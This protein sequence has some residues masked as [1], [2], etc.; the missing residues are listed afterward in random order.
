MSRSCTGVECLLYYQP[1]I[2]TPH[3]STTRP[4]VTDGVAWPVG[5]SRSWL[6]QKRL[7]RSRCR[8]V[9]VLGA[10]KEPRIRWGYRSLCKGAIWGRKGQP[11]LKY[12]DLPWAVHKGGTDPDAIWGMHSGRPVFQGSMCYRRVHIGSTWRIRLNRPRRRCVKLLWPLVIK[13]ANAC[14]VQA[15]QISSL[16][17]Q[18]TTF[19]CFC[20]LIGNMVVQNTADFSAK[21]N[22]QTDKV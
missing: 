21:Y 18:C 22:C 4:I 11:I 19:G 7:N 8:L 9:C 3:R 14:R 20:F 17:K 2:I 5:L 13:P 6:L 12:R 15:S 16:L 10:P 1:K